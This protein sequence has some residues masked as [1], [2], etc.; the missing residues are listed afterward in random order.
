LK[1]ASNYTLWYAIVG[2][3]SL[4]LENSIPRELFTHLTNYY[5]ADLVQFNPQGN[6]KKEKGEIF[7]KKGYNFPL[8]NHWSL[9]DSMLHS[10][11]L[12]AKLSLWNDKGL[13]RLHEILTKLGISL[14]QAKQN[15]KYMLKEVKDA[16]EAKIFTITTDYNLG[17][18]SFESFMRQTDTSSS[19]MASDIYYIIVSII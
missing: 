18:I 14:E 13:T 1:R 17:E 12:M 5:R 8:M 6:E 16:L 4:Y 9:H 10:P 11:Y 7:L 3:T 19:Y 2:L 15:Y